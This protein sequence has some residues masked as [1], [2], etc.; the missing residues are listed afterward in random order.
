M[1]SFSFRSAFVQLSIFS[2]FRFSTFFQLI[3]THAFQS[4]HYAINFSTFH[5]LNSSDSKKV[6][7]VKKNVYINL[8]IRSCFCNLLKLFLPYDYRHIHHHFHHHHDSSGELAQQSASATT[9]T[10][11]VKSTI[12]ENHST[13][14]AT[15]W[16][17]L[18]RKSA[19]SESSGA[20]NTNTSGLINNVSGVTTGLDVTGNLSGSN[21][22][23]LNQSGGVLPNLRA[24]H[25]QINNLQTTQN[26]QNNQINQTHQINQNQQNN[27]NFQQLN[28]QNRTID[29][30]QHNLQ[31]TNFNLFRPQQAIFNNDN[32]QNSTGPSI[33]PIANNVATIPSRQLNQNVRP[34]PTGAQ[35]DR[36]QTIPQHS[37]PGAAMS[38][39][40]QMSTNPSGHTQTSQTNM[41]ASTTN[42]GNFEVES[43]PAT[44]SLDFM[45]E[46]E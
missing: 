39:L 6:K 7:K 31:T 14:T 18:K 10:Q 29:N 24:K 46:I 28:N 40:N 17:G 3:Q 23:N 22:E 34:P 21:F 44:V 4:Y 26:I 41:Q 45:V 38:Y 36:S 25:I 42:T 35:I 16:W 13:A 37:Q 33:S 1:L 9:T 27:L 20:E 32:T 43:S 8:E 11:Q 30:H 12:P 5:A 19:N 15:P 2:N